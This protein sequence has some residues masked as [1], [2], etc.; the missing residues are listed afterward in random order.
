MDAVRQLCIHRNTGQ[1]PV[2][3]PAAEHPVQRVHAEQLS[4]GPQRL[5]QLPQRR[6]IQV[7]VS[8]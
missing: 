8:A 2:V 5:G 7:Q 6:R 3:L 4:R 1:E